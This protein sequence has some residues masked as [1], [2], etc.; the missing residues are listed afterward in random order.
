MVCLCAFRNT[1]YKGTDRVSSDE[2]DDVLGMLSNVEASNASLCVII[3]Q[4]D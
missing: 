2:I 3:I 1:V 4:R